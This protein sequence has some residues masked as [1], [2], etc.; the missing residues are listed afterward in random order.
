MKYY[1]NCKPEELSEHIENGYDLYDKEGMEE[2]MESDETWTEV[3]VIP[4]ATISIKLK[5]E[6]TKL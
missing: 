2:N 5:P 3:D 4:V 6:R 1:A